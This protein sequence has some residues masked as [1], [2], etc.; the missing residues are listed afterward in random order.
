MAQIEPLIPVDDKSNTEGIFEL[1]DTT[2]LLYKNL[3]KIK[4]NQ[5][6]KGFILI[7]LATFIQCFLIIQQT[8][9]SAKTRELDHQQW[10][11]YCLLLPISS[12][13][14][15]YPLGKNHI[16]GDITCLYALK[17]VMHNLWPAKSIWFVK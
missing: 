15:E 4:D 7:S 13:T 17:L 14:K 12:A 16:M 1:V 8:S 3:R 2:Q 6:G 10:M 11:K 9:C 5:N